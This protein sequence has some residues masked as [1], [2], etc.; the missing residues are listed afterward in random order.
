MKTTISTQR[1]WQILT[2]ASIL[3]LLASFI[4]TIER[5]DFAKNPKVGLS[6]DINAVFSCSNVFDAW[7]SSVFGFTNSLLCVV[8]FAIIAGVALAGTFGGQIHRRLRLI[9]HFFSVFFLAFGAWY[10]WQS[11]FVIGYICIFCLIC[12]SAVIA[13]NWAWLRINAKDLPLSKK[14]RAWLT[15]QIT[16]HNDTV[17][18]ILYAILVGGIIIFHFW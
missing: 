6:C 3:G 14:S 9:L 8:F 11:T 18:W 7:Q 17:A 13:M 4:Q 2:G 16:Q 12:Y 10:L 15:S 1:L 5:I